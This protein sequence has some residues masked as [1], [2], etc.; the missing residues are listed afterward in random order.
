[1]YAINKETKKIYW[2]VDSKNT[3]D[4]EILTLYQR[5]EN[6]K[7]TMEV[8]EV[9]Y[10]FQIKNEP[11]DNLDAEVLDRLKKYQIKAVF[12]ISPVDLDNIFGKD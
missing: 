10:K 2:I 9:Q 11:R 3:S 1:M 6:V 4:G 12:G 7:F 5:E 8:N